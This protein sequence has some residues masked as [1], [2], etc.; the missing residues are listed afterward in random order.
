MTSQ[1]IQTFFFP[2]SLPIGEKGIGGTLG[3]RG[4]TGPRGDDGDNG[5]PGPQGFPGA[6]NTVPGPK[7]PDGDKGDVGRDGE[8]GPNGPDGD[9]AMAVYTDFFNDNVFKSLYHIPRIEINEQNT[10]TNTMIRDLD[11]MLSNKR[12]W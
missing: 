1:P 5:D 3:I 12:G 4:P 7:G 2:S 9:D 10:N 11:T 8:Q 6:D